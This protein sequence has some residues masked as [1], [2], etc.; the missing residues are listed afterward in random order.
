MD[1]DGELSRNLSQVLPHGGLFCRAGGTYQGQRA[2]CAEG[3]SGKNG[4]NPQMRAGTG[5]AYQALGSI[6]GQ[7]WRKLARIGTPHTTKALTSSSRTPAR[8]VDLHL[9]VEPSEFPSSRVRLVSGQR[10]VVRGRA[11]NGASRRAAMLLCSNTRQ[12]AD[13]LARL[14]VRAFRPT[15]P[16]AGSAVWPV[17]RPGSS[18]PPPVGTLLPYAR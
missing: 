17:A 4:L 5:R 11:S 14:R 16:R 2:G 13:G 9:G 3:R 1:G 10:S 6:Q 8:H 18:K 12:G 7:T 15:Y